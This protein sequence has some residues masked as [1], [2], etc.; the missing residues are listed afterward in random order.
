MAVNE[1]SLLEP[2]EPLR[3]EY[4]DWLALKSDSLSATRDLQVAGATDDE[5]LVAGALR[6]REEAE[7]EADA[8]ATELGLDECASAESY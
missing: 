8:L 6:A 1:L 2:P 5:E 4:E 7:T 3:E